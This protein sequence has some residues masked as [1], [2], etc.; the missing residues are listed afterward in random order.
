MS[1]DSVPVSNPPSPS[2]VSSIVPPPHN[3]VQ[4]ADGEAQLASSV[5]QDESLPVASTSQ[6]VSMSLAVVLPF[7]GLLAAIVLLWQFGWMGWQYLALLVLGHVITGMGITIGFH[8]LLAHRSFETYRPVRA[9]WMMMGALSVQGSPIVWCAIHRRH[10]GCSD[11]HG[12]PHSPNLHGSG[13]RGMLHGLWHGQVGWLF[14]GFWSAPD[15]ERYVPDLMREKWLVRI[16]KGYYWFVV[17]SLAIPAAIGFWIGG[18]WFGA[19]L[20]FLWGGLA[21]IFMTHHITWSINS[22][23]HVFGRR[24][25]EAGD[26]STNN[27]LCALLGFGEGWHNNHHAFPNSARHGL[28]WWQLDTSWWVIRGMQL[29]GLAW[30][31][32]LPTKRA[33]ASKR[34]AA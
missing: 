12:D 7:I 30:N 33:M 2:G 13:L 15:F 18:G 19:L 20:G 23:C 24:P 5:S 21:R 16:D 17:A 4:I 28:Q 10:H 6:K 27:L 1:I 22:V 29:C 3:R 25:F 14:T 8:R 32:K 26:H 11:Q 9:F 31:V 34:R